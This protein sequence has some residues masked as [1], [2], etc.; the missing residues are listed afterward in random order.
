MNCPK[1]GREIPAGS[2][3]CLHCNSRFSDERT[4]VMVNDDERDEVRD[5]LRTALSGVYELD[6]E[7]GHGGMAVVYKATEIELRRPVALKVLPP[8]MLVTKAAV[9]RFKR[10]ARM[11]AALDHPNI[12]PIYRIGQAAGVF[13]IAMKFVEGRSLHGIMESQGALPLPVVLNVFRAATSGLAY[14]HEREIVHRDI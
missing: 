6:Q 13:Y 9:E 8:G 7:L 5:T 10:E 4:L 12:I 3:T 2:P 1:C 14:A 11:A